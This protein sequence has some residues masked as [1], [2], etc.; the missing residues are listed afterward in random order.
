[1]HKAPSL[2]GRD[3][4]ETVDC[5]CLNVSGQSIPCKQL[6][7]YVRHLSDWH[8]CSHEGASWRPPSHTHGTFCA[9]QCGVAYMCQPQ[10][11]GDATMEACL[12]AP[13]PGS[14]AS[15]WVAMAVS[16]YSRSREEQSSAKKTRYAASCTCWTCTCSSRVVPR[17]WKACTHSQ[18]AVS[19]P[20]HREDGQHGALKA[21]TD[22]GRAASLY[23]QGKPM[24]RGCKWI[25]EMRPG[26]LEGPG[27]PAEGRGRIWQCSRKCGPA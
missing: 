1:M 25:C 23:S 12:T 11:P 13:A 26:G 5:L 14:T 10:W 19:L 9:K 22:A 20:N 2:L 3:R 27:R 15:S 21:C 7:C 4:G 6:P 8:L 24:A 17:A 16:S 18:R